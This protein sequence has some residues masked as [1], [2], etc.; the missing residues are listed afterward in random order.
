MDDGVKREAALA[1]IGATL[2]FVAS[3]PELDATRVAVVGGSYGGY[4]VLATAVLHPDRIRAAVDIVGISSLP[5]FLESTQAYRRDLRRAEYG[6]ERI[7]E[8][9]A[10]QERISPLAHAA[11]IRAPLF[12]IQGANDPRVPRSEAEQIVSAARGN[13]QE[14]WYLLALDEGHGFRKKENR[15]F[16][17]AATALFLE[18]QLNGPVAPAPGE[19][20][21]PG[22]NAPAR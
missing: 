3:R 19:A 1:D 17:L 4:L 21:A 11:R 9:R 18:R 10:V 15:D 20:P 13:G 8:V 5:S 7:P 16:Y 12:V 14:I 6:D 22:A 2:D